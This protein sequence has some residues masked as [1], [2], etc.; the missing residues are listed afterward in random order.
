MNA[1]LYLNSHAKKLYNAVKS[2]MGLGGEVPGKQTSS[3]QKKQQNNRKK[4]EQSVSGREVTNAAAPAGLPVF[5]EWKDTPQQSNGYDCGIY[6]LAISRAIVD[7]FSRG[8]DSKSDMLSVVAKHVD[9]SVEVRMQSEI[10]KLIDDLR[11]NPVQ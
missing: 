2:Y 10:L 4:N 8:M 5:K 9:Q 1:F 7:W 11:K 6:V 3:S